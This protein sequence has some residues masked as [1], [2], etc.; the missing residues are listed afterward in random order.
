MAT[1][2]PKESFTRLIHKDP[3]TNRI[4]QDLYDKLLQLQR[5][6]DKITTTTKP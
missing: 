6:L 5:A 1:Q 3:A 2:P 4:I